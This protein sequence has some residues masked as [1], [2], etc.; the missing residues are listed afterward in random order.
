MRISR[1]LLLLAILTFVKCQTDPQA[2][3]AVETSLN[4]GQAPTAD[5][6]IDTKFDKTDEET[7][8]VLKQF[9]EDPYLMLCIGIFSR[10]PPAFFKKKAASFLQVIEDSNK[11]P[12]YLDKYVFRSMA[13]CLK[14]AKNAD[15]SKVEQDTQS[16][17]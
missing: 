3:D 14:I 15:L 7:A 4:N 2:T 13:N 8:A 5:T 16:V 12:L 1:T 11:H 17:I 10:V 9:K 6:S